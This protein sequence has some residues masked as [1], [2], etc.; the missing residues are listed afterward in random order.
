MD[1]S[2]APTFENIIPCLT[3]YDDHFQSYSSQHNVSP[4]LAFYTKRGRGQYYRSR[5]CSQGRGSF[6]T[7]G[8]GFDQH[9]S[10]SSGSSV[11]SDSDS[12]PTCQICGKT[13][14]NALRCW[15]RFENR[16]L[17][18]SLMSQTATVLNGSLI[19]ALLLTLPAL[20]TISNKLRSTLLLT[21]LW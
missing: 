21:R 3:S 5:G 18:V 15:H 10:S 4:H 17:C 7:R 12:R 13:G 14:H 6:S 16:L 11:S 20:L 9:V 1:S 8:R 19:Q 2:H